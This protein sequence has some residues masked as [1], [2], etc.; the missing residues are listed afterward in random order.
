MQSSRVFWSH[1]PWCIPFEWP[2]SFF[3]CV[4]PSRSMTGSRN[5]P[6]RGIFQQPVSLTRRHGIP[7]RLRCGFFVRA[8]AGRWFRWAMDVWK[9][10][11]AWPGESPRPPLEMTPCPTQTGSPPVGWWAGCCAL[12]LADVPVHLADRAGIV[13]GFVVVAEGG[14][15]RFVGDPDEHHRRDPFHS[16]CSAGHRARDG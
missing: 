4:M 8:A 5:S 16:S 15:A 3:L 7:C 13:C 1:A 6:Q 2:V 11:R 9:I 10:S 14:V 12:A